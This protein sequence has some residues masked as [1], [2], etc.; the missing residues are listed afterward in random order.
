[1]LALIADEDDP[2]NACVAS[3]VQQRVNLP[4]PEET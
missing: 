2:R 3:H 4:R 1:M